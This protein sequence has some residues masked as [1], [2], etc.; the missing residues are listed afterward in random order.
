MTI[1]MESRLVDLTGQAFERLDVYESY[2]SFDIAREMPRDLTIFVWGACV[3]MEGGEK[4]EDWYAKGTAPVRFSDVTGWSFRVS[5]YYDNGD[6][7]RAADGTIVKLSRSWGALEGG[8]GHLYELQGVS[9]WPH[10]ECD[11]TVRCRGPVTIDLAGV[12]VLRDAAV[13]D[14]VMPP[15][16]ARRRAAATRTISPG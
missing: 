7:V 6:F 1:E 5:L 11:V 16:I 3:F 14:R 15:E 4:G 9:L 13:T 10:G 2:L 12:E 8:E